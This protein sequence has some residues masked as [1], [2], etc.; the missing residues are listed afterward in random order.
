MRR[1][2]QNL[3]WQG[4]QFFSY[5]HL[6]NLAQVYRVN[7][8]YIIYVIY[9]CVW[10][11]G[12]GDTVASQSMLAISYTKAHGTQTQCSEENAGKYDRNDDTHLYC[13][14][15]QAAVQ[16]RA[17]NAAS[18]KAQWARAAHTLHTQRFC[19]A[20]VPLTLAVWNGRYVNVCANC[21]SV[22]ER[23]QER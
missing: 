5:T 22:R 4:R 8:L 16:L 15:L 11:R 17:T 6:E 9:I 12:E 21:A 13:T 2:R 23:E 10:D 3:S 14:S 20:H 1:V 19:A 18:M 7:Y